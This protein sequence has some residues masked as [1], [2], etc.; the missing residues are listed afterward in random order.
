MSGSIWGGFVVGTEP[1]SMKSSGT[2]S[3]AVR[4]CGTVVWMSRSTRA[5]CPL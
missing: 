3:R 5:V 2:R 1:R 4:S